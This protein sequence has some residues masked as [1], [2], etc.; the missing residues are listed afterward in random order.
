MKNLGIILGLS[1]FIMLF[2]C[3]QGGAQSQPQP[4]VTTPEQPVLPGCHVVTMSE[5]YT[6]TMCWNVTY[7]QE[8][9][10]REALEYTVSRVR[11]I[12]LCT[13]DGACTGKPVA[14]CPYTCNNAMK[15]CQMDITNLNTEKSGMWVVGA[16]FTIP[17]MGFEKEPQRLLISPGQ[18]VTFDFTQLY[19]LGLKGTSVECSLYV[20]DAPV[21]DFCHQES[22]T[23]T[24]C[25][26]VTVYRTIEKEVC[27]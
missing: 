2:G 25:D 22:M 19:T 27:G 12:D 17:N 24:E 3:V 5:P 11:T 1:I 16:N 18:T 6:E 21:A 20:M 7:T 10:D 14:D 13:G 23:E 8:V 9:C 26:E 15:R 4:L